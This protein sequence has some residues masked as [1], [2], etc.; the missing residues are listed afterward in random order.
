MKKASGWDVGKGLGIEMMVR[1]LRFS[2]LVSLLCPLYS[3]QRHHRTVV[4]NGHPMESDTFFRMHWNCGRI[5]LQSP[6]GRF[7]GII[8]NGLLMANATIPGKHRNLLPGYC[9]SEMLSEGAGI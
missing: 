8:D 3:L 9:N 7:L 6:N 1:K 5:I 2:V 4:A